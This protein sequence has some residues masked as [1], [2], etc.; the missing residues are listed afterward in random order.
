ML[1]QERDLL[2]LSREHSVVDTQ[3][4]QYNLKLNLCLQQLY[5]P[6]AFP[7]HRLALKFLICGDRGMT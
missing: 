4:V 1:R 7:H 6:S 2:N 5:Y 3:E